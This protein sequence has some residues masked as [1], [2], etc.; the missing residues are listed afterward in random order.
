MP[1]TLQ[2]PAGPMVAKQVQENFITYFRHF[3]GLPGIT[4]VEEDVTWIASHGAPGSMVLST[5][6]SGD[7]ADQQIDATLRRIGQHTNAVDWF[8]FSG[9][10]PA[11]LGSRLVARAEAG[12][13]H[14]E[15]MLYGNIGGPG[16]T[17]MLAD[18]TALPASTPVPDNFHVKQVGDQA[19]LDEWTKIN[20]R[21][22]GGSDYS[23]FHAA[24]A[25]HG[26]GP[27]AQAVHFIGY[28]GDEPVTSSTLLMAGGSA[29]VYNVST[30]TDLRRR[31]FGGAITQAALQHAFERGYLS[32]WIWSSP[33]G[34]GVYAKLGFVVTDFG[35]REYQ[36]K[37]NS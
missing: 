25:R 22:F 26:F 35:V 24:Y 6:L 8:V 2:M 10:Q 34:K 32:A 28:M 37:K 18:L 27:H 9:C 17:W 14:D 19:M 16:G 1:N 15:W 31:G 4:F 5:Q 23:A 7:E 11:D 21:G 3:A 12:G 36:W 33:L 29:S 30:P 20:A 13:P